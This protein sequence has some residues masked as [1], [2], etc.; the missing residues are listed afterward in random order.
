MRCWRMRC[1]DIRRCWWKIKPR[2]PA[3]ESIQFWWYDTPLVWNW[4]TIGIY[5]QPVVDDEL[6]VTVSD[7]SKAQLIDVTRQWQ[8]EYTRVYEWHFNILSEWSFQVTVASKNNPNLSFTNSY[9][10]QI[11]VPVETFTFEDQ[12]IN[13]PSWGIAMFNATYTPTDAYVWS[14]LDVRDTEE[15]DTY[16]H[17]YSWT[18]AGSLRMYAMSSA[19]EWATRT[20]VAKHF[21]EPVGSVE[22]DIIENILP[23]TA[24]FTE[25][26]ITMTAWE[27]HT[28]Q[29]TTVPAD[30]TVVFS[31]Q[32]ENYDIASNSL[33]EVYANNP[34]TTTLH[35]L[36]WSTWVEYDTCEVTVEAPV[37]PTIEFVDWDTE[38][39]VGETWTLR[40]RYTNATSFSCED[41]PF[42]A[43]V[44]HISSDEEYCYITYEWVSDWQAGIHCIAWNW[45]VNIS[46]SVRV[47]VIWEQPVLE[48]ITA[49]SQFS[50]DYRCNVWD[51]WNWNLWT[52]T[53]SE[54]GDINSLSY[55]WGEWMQFWWCDIVNGDT[56]IGHIT[57]EETW[58]KLFQIQLQNWNLYQYTFHV[59]ENIPVESIE[60]HFAYNIDVP[61]W[62]ATTVQFSYLPANA[63]NFSGITWRWSVWAEEIAQPWGWRHD[64]WTLYWNINWIGEWSCTLTWML[65]DVWFT[66]VNAIVADPNPTIEPVDPDPIIPDDPGDF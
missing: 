17:I 8:D 16:A 36:D 15:W 66:T 5:C 18:W 51:T 30:C 56:L 64:N 47:T 13:V 2:K 23:E 7:P 26:S 31:A 29:V 40:F 55:A 22:A 3:F 28:M 46:A 19:P 6:V 52:V 45:N 37:Y 62:G 34:W 11:P 10:A 65:N 27:S 59:S 38:I 20:M 4:R 9:Y 44:T 58:D 61:V 53:P 21:D 35:L 42:I 1:W 33:L 60:E 54:N 14:W 48:P 24:E 43:N 50:T 57:R 32:P 12:N 39:A 49:I 41:D 25:H 63:T